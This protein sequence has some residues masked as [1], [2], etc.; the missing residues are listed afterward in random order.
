M[1]FLGGGWVRGLVRSRRRRGRSTTRTPSPSVSCPIRPPTFEVGLSDISSTTG[2]GIVEGS[3]ALFLS[4]CCSGGGLQG[5]LLFSF[6]L[7][8]Y[9]CVDTRPTTP[10][11]EEP[12]P[13]VARPPTRRLGVGD[14]KEEEKRIRETRT[15]RRETSTPRRTR[16]CR[17]RSTAGNDPVGKTST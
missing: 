13:S 10:V 2:R 16:G 6:P 4:L 9:S 15:E 12:T 5:P 17:S 1:S 8:S 14:G 11:T 7:V 3:S